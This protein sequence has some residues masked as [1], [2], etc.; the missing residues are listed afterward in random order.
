MAKKQRIG[1]FLWRHATTISVALAVMFVFAIA[2][3]GYTYVKVTS[4]FDSSRMWDLPSRIYSDATPIATGQSYPREMLEPKLNYLGYFE[5]GH[6]P[7]K[8]GEYRFAGGDL[9]IYL[10]EFRYPDLDFPGMPVEI[11]MSGDSV[12]AIHRLDDESTLKAVRLEPELITSIFDDEMEDRIPIPLDRVPEDLIDAIIAMED[13]TFFEH[14]GI[15]LRGIARAAWRDIRN[16]SLEHGGST[17]TQQLVKNLYLTPE[18]TWTRKAWEA[19]M[20]LILDARYS[21]EQILEAYINEIYLGQNGSVQIVGVE[22][23][24]QVFFGKRAINLDLP[25]AA[26][27][28]AVIQSPNYYSPLRHPERAKKRRNLALQAMVETG[29]IT[30]EEAERA[31]EAPVEVNPYPRSIRSAPY[32]VD[33]VLKELRETYPKTQLTSEG[34][35]VFTTLDTMMQRSAEETL[36]DGLARLERDYPRISRHDEPPEGTLITIQPG[37]GYVKTLVGGSS[38]AKSQFNRAIQAKRQPGSIFKPFVYVT[39]MDPSL[40][41]EALTASTI[42]HDTPITVRTGTSEWKPQ[43]YDREFHGNISVREALVKS[44]NIPAV[45]AAISVGIQNVVAMASRIG[46]ES[47]L[48][49]YPSIS[50]GSFEVTPL[51]IA[52]AY[53]VFANQ[54]VKAEPVTILS[55]VTREGELLESRVVEM[56]RVADPALM[57]VMNDILQDVVSRGTASRV[58]AMGFNRPFAGKTGTTN[59]YRDAWFVGYSPRVLTLV[60]VGYDDGRNMGLSGSSAA[61][62]IWTRYMKRVAGLVP[63]EDF[64]R[65]DGVM[66]REIDPT[67]G[68]LTTPYCPETR[69][70]I[71]VE[72]TA[73]E[74]L[75]PVHSAYDR[76]P[77]DW[78]DRSDREDWRGPEDR[79]RSRERNPIRRFLEDLFD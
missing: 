58:R 62:P 55:V 43:N 15:S 53:S 26:T 36:A 59:D 3:V 23:A 8:P 71:Y 39:A 56:E 13:R 64:R 66:T 73:P 52:F 78:D 25:E 60:W 20:A 61:V 50:L 32:F 22:Q 51:E 6:E 37:T 4:K 34:L 29:A 79:R 12:T 76:F 77:Y 7:E 68:F 67:T 38:Y 41:D 35:R 11:R 9:E 17:L 16:R 19:L 2:F 48:E 1:R 31:K 46:V 14:E 49:P 18:R 44:Y 28:A 30:E 70:E 47:P 33:L 24:S 72:G 63:D 21:K 54:G 5:V 57:Y 65:P 69:K 42:L 74:R 27:I 45:R 75:C 10:H 40:G